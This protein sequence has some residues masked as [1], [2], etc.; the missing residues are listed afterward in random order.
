MRI[1]DWS[2]DV[3][4]SDLAA[5]VRQRRE[6]VQGD[7]TLGGVG[8]VVAD[9]LDVRNEAQRGEDFAQVARQ[10]PAQRQRHSVLADLAFEL[11]DLLAAAD[12]PLGGLVVTAVH[13]VQGRL[14]PRW[15]PRHHPATYVVYTITPFCAAT[16]AGTG[17]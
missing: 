11:V 2:S 10:R 16:Y 7:R 17:G 1:S 9:P 13:N 4:S 5:R 8:R 3:C 14:P 15:G 6:R 12:D